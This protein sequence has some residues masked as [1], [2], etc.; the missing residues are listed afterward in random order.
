MNLGKPSEGSKRGS[1]V[2]DPVRIRQAMAVLQQAEVEF[3]IKVEGAH[4]L[5][6]TSRLQHIDEAKGHLH[7]KLIRPLPHELAI[8]ATFEMRF[9][10]DD[11]HFEAPIVFQGRESYL[12]YRFTLPA[13]MTQS[14]RRG[15]KR[16][17]FR[18]REKAYVLA[19]DAGLPG[20]GLA[21][22]LVNLSLGGLAF[23]VDRVV[24][25]D[26]H[27]RVTPGL[28]FY[29][30]GK[31]LP[32][33]KLRDLPKHPLVEARGTI[34]NAWERYGEI[35]VGVQFGELKEA[36]RHLLEEVLAIREQMQRAP[37]IPGTAE[38]KP[39]RKQAGAPEVKSPAGRMNPAGG[40]VPDALVRLG[41]RTTSLVLA[42]APG[43]RRE[44]VRAALGIAGYLRLSPVD[45]L[46]HA[47]QVLRSGQDATSRLLVLDT[48]AGTE[49]PLAEIRA[50]QQEL[51]ELR[52]LPVAL[53]R[54]GDPPA[55]PGEAL[56]RPLPWPG[57][58]PEAWLP[59]L[60]ELAGLAG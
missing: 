52:E 60:D 19:Q 50:L 42:M 11:H 28:G 36:E 27:L 35:V 21:G 2:E 20:F 31:E 12:L 32:M 33:I 46:D 14:D 57:Q 54:A 53:I 47:L 24:R 22:P 5:P 59:I 4:T 38:P 16:Y 56:I 43:P 8:G 23:R 13:Q 17:P 40:L 39:S 58:A 7:L 55:D 25:L 6:Y 9:A 41:R 49:P 44:E 15:H 30:R 37:S 3:P 26:D 48:P 18:P 10:L 51:G 34:A 1:A 45:S 29:D